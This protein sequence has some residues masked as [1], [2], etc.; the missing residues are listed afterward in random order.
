MKRI[1]S[2]IAIMA[3]FCSVLTA[4][5]TS[6]EVKEEVSSTSVS[7]APAAAAPTTTVNFMI[8]CLGG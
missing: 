1:V 7:S 5:G 8:Q 3:A 2:F 4:C 6:A